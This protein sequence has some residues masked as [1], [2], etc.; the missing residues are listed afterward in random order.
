M[1]VNLPRHNPLKRKK[2]GLWLNIEI[3]KWLESYHVFDIDDYLNINGT[4]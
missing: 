3:M 2:K 4:K 1:L